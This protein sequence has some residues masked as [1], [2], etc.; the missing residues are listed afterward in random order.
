MDDL[1]VRMAESAHRGAFFIEQNGEKVGVMA[2]TR[3]GPNTV[4]IE[5]TE[6]GDALKGKGAGRKLLDA[7]VTWARET[8]TKVVPVC[9]YATAQFQKDPS[10]RDVLAK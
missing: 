7:L 10:I 6:V 3:T 2:F 4:T 5:H 8:E 9:P 1:S